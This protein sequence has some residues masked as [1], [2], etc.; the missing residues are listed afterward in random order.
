[1]RLDSSTDEKG[2]SV[3]DSGIFCSFL[4]GVVRL[5]WIQVEQKLVS[6]EKKKKKF[7]I[8]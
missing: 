2:D 7:Q 1:M 5:Y 6:N 4:D 8:I 3:I